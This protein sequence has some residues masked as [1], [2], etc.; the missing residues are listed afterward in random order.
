[1]QLFQEVPASFDV[2][3]LKSDIGMFK[4][5]PIAHFTG[6]VVPYRLILHHLPAAGFV[7][8]FY[9][10]FFLAVHLEALLCLIPAKNILYRAGHHMMNAGKAVR[11]GW[12]LV[13]GKRGRPFALFNGA[14]ED[15]FLQPAGEHIL[16]ETGQ[17]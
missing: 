4:I 2:R 1:M 13:K 9:G 7:I 17:I 11:R 6:Q 10:D 14:F 16:R 3:I 15:A 8:V 5:D 12:S